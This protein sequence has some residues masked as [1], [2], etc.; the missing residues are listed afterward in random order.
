M[1]R[2]LDHAPK[3]KANCIQL[4]REWSI[5]I[6]ATVA[7]PALLADQLG[8]ADRILTA[9]SSGAMPMHAT[10]YSELANW[11]TE[12]FR[13]LDSLSLRKLR[14]VAPFELQEIIE[15]VLHERHVVS[16]AAND[17]V[18]LSSLAECLAFVRRCRSRAQPA[19]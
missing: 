10:G 2:V 13:A 17:L 9:L 11:V 5:C 15:N 4:R 16:W 7:L 18:C 1:H 14:N 19:S 8:M 6:H 12:S 3:G